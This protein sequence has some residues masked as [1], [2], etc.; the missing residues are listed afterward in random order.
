MEDCSDKRIAVIKLG[1]SVLANEESYREAARFLGR[2]LQ[3][4]PGGQLV[5]VVSAQY[6]CTDE[7]E[8]LARSASKN[9][10]RRT[11]DLLWSTG[12]LRSAALLAL[13]LQNMGISTI[14]LNAHEA[15]LRRNGSEHIEADSVELEAAL[16]NHSIL[17]VPGF[18]ATT[19]SGT[20]L[21]LG[22]GGSDL[23]AVLFAQ[24]LDAQQ[25]ELI[26]DVDGYFNKDPH[27]DGKAARL[28]QLSY[29]TALKMAD[30]GCELV[31][32][33]ALEA[34]RKAGL[35]LV[36]RSLHDNATGSVVSENESAVE[37]MGHGTSTRKA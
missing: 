6:G 34:A 9:P 8:S 30:E 27:L 10:N 23:S 24:A 4:C 15:G 25:C 19:K 11:L 32:W 31:Q 3:K 16:A 22:R 18:F 26:K 5:I 35:R 20:L 17:V 13:H 29:E 28:P 2:R 14:A 7:L 33:R 36:I 12:E 21:S 37:S 1:G